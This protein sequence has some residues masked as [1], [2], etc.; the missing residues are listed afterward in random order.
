LSRTDGLKG[1]LPAVGNDENGP[2]AYIGIELDTG[3]ECI[4]AY[5]VGTIVEPGISPHPPRDARS[6]LDLIALAPSR[7]DRDGQSSRSLWNN[8]SNRR[9]RS[10][11]V[12]HP[13]DAASRPAVSRKSESERMRATPTGA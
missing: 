4:W 10:P 1:E 2:A 6:E 9:G 12:W 11:H 13:D 8:R 7:P 3:V 5:P